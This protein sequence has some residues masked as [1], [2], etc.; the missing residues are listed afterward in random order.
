M[1]KKRIVTFLGTQ[2][3]LLVLGTHIYGTSG[4]INFDNTETD[5]INTTIGNYYAKSYVQFGIPGASSDDVTATVYF[6][7]IKIIQHQ[8]EG[9][10]DVNGFGSALRLIIPPHTAV[11][12]TLTNIDTTTRDGFCIV[13]GRVYDA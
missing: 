10:A 2:K 12:I 8:V 4:A 6:N 5:L 3:G 9:T 7:G 13:T 11:R 1:A